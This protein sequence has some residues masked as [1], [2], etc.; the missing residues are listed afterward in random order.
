MNK[1]KKRTQ[2]P[3]NFGPLLTKQEPLVDADINSIVA[4]YMKT[5]QVPQ[6]AGQPR[7]GDFTGPSY[8]EM[9]NA[10]ADIDMQ[11]LQL[12]ARVRKM[13]SNDPLNLVRFVNE[14]KNQPQAIKLGLIVSPPGEDSF[15]P[16]DLSQATAASVQ[17]IRDAF[18]KEEPK[19]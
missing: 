8:L 16:E 5:G 18:K 4:R 12:P 17:E 3:K 19:K 2:K 1:V 6:P 10:I 14:P 13:F 7:F 11:F 15:E 9:R